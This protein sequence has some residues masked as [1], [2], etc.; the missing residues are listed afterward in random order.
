MSFGAGYGPQP[1]RSSGM[2]ASAQDREAAEAVLKQAF[3]D[4]RLTQDEFEA[5]LGQAVAARTVGEL[6]SLTRDLPAVSPVPPVRLRPRRPWLVVAGVVGVLALIGGTITTLGV[7][8]SVSSSAHQSGQ[9]AGAVGPG[10]PA[11]CPVGTA[12]IAVRI[13]NALARDPVYVD[14]GSGLVPAAQ[15][16][17]VQ[18]EI[19]RVDPGRIRIAAVTSATLRRGGGERALANAIASCPAVSAGTTMVTTDQNTYLVTSYTD[20]SAA[21]SAVNAAMNTHTSL[22]ASLLD[23]V[24]RL[25]LVDKH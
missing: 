22:G 7:P 1:D 24:R 23:A 12:A 13:A 15:A 25:A 10:G 3:E 6:T 16:R 5:R 8:S 11:R 18:E 14:A 19:S 2:L 4:E 20:T 21:T 17:Q 9:A